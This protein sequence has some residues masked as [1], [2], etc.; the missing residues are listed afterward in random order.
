MFSKKE[1]L[2]LIEGV[3][4]GAK[5]KDLV[6]GEFTAMI[7]RERDYPDGD[8]VCKMLLRCV[9][10]FSDPAAP[11]RLFVVSEDRSVY[12]LI[13]VSESAGILYAEDARAIQ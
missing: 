6:P 11:G 13:P 4:P 2:S 9:A 1:L 5:V 8:D 12:S 3:L 7:F 10:R